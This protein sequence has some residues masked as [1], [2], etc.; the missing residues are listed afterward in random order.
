MSTLPQLRKNIKFFTNGKNTPLVKLSSMVS[1]GEEILAVIAIESP[2]EFN[3]C[4]KIRRDLF[5]LLPADSTEVLHDK[6]YS[7]R[8]IVYDRMDIESALRIEFGVE[9]GS[10]VIDSTTFYEQ[11][12]TLIKFIEVLNN[13]FGYDL[14]TDDITLT[15]TSG[16]N[17]TVTARPNSVVFTGQ[18]S[19]NFGSESDTPPPVKVP[20]H[21]S[22]WENTLIN[23]DVPARVNGNSVSLKNNQAMFNAGIALVQY[24]TPNLAWLIWTGALD[25]EATLTATNEQAVISVANVNQTL[26]KTDE[27]LYAKYTPFI[28][29]TTVPDFLNPITA[30]D[31]VKSMTFSIPYVASLN[32]I[33]TFWINDVIVPITELVKE[34]GSNGFKLVINPTTGASTLTHNGQ[35][36][37]RVSIRVNV[38]TLPALVRSGSRFIY[39]IQREGNNLPLD[40]TGRE[41]YHI[42]FPA[43]E[44]IIPDPSEITPYVPTNQVDYVAA[45]DK[46]N[47]GLILPFADYLKTNPVISTSPTGR[48]RLTASVESETYQPRYPAFYFISQKDW[49]VISGQSVGT[50]LGTYNLSTT[51]A[52]NISITVGLLL[53]TTVP[54]EGGRLLCIVSDI[55]SHIDGSFKLNYQPGSEYYKETTTLLRFDVTYTKASIITPRALDRTI[56]REL[57]GSTMTDPNFNLMYLRQ[58][59]VGRYINQIG[60]A[61][62]VNYEYSPP[63]TPSVVTSSLDEDGLY[64]LQLFSIPSAAMLQ[65]QGIAAR[66]PSA[67]I[68]SINDSAT[69]TTRNLT[70]L[71]IVQTAAIQQGSGDGY[72]YHRLDK[73]SGAT[74]I[75]WVFNCD[76]DEDDL[77]YRQ[78][79]TTVNVANSVIDLPLIPFIVG[80]QECNNEIQYDLFRGVVESGLIEPTEIFDWKQFK[81]VISDDSL[82]GLFVKFGTETPAL[83]TVG[84]L[85]LGVEQSEWIR[86]S[87]FS[88]SVNTNPDIIII[89]NK[90]TEQ[91]FNIKADY[92]KSNADTIG[93]IPL[94]LP[95]F[96]DQV[97]L[98]EWEFE[99]EWFGFG[100]APRPTPSALP[101]LA[102]GKLIIQIQ[103][104]VRPIQNIPSL[105][106]FTSSFTEMEKETLRNKLIEVGK[107]INPIDDIVNEYNVVILEDQVV[108]AADIGL[109]KQDFLTDWV[110]GEVDHLILEVIELDKSILPQ[111]VSRTFTEKELDTVV[112]RFI[113]GSTTNTQVDKVITVRDIRQRAF[114]NVSQGFIPVVGE[115][116][117]VLEFDDPKQ[118]TQNWIADYSILNFEDEKYDPRKLNVQTFVYLNDVS[119][120]VLTLKGIK[121]NVFE[122]DLDVLVSK[123]WTIGELSFIPVADQ[124]I[125]A[126]N[127]FGI[128]NVNYLNKGK[129]GFEVLEFSDNALRLLKTAEKL[130]P[131][132]TVFTL[133]ISSLDVDTK[134]TNLTATELLDKLEEGKLLTIPLTALVKSGDYTYDIAISLN[135]SVTTSITT[136]TLINNLTSIKDVTPPDV[137]VDV[138]WTLPAND[139]EL[140]TWCASVG[141]PPITMTQYGLMVTEFEYTH[142]VTVDRS[143]SEYVVALVVNKAV[144][145][146]LIENQFT[147]NTIVGEF[148]KTNLYIEQ[149][150]EGI[151]NDAGD[152][153]LLV[154]APVSIE[155]ANRYN[156]SFEF[157]GVEPYNQTFTGIDIPVVEATNVLVT[158]IQNSMSQL[159]TSL[160]EALNPIADQLVTVQDLNSVEIT[161]T[162]SI[163]NILNGVSR[164]NIGKKW[165]IP[166]GIDKS[167]LDNLKPGSWLVINI[168]NPDTTVTVNTTQLTQFVAEGWTYRDG[169]T[170]IDY[171][172]YPLLF[173]FTDTEGVVK[174]NS[175][176]DAGASVGRWGPW[177]TNYKTTI[178]FEYSIREVSQTFVEVLIPDQIVVDQLQTELEI[179]EGFIPTNTF[180]KDTVLDGVTVKVNDTSSVSDIGK[181]VPLFV[182]FLTTQLSALPSDITLG[183]VK[184]TVFNKKIDGSYL[185]SDEENII[186]FN[187]LAIENGKVV[188]DH[189]YVL[190]GGVYNSTNP[191]AITYQ[192]NFDFDGDGQDWLSGQS[193]TGVIIELGYNVDCTGALNYAGSIDLTATNGTILMNSEGNQIQVNN[194]SEFTNVLRDTFGL[195]VINI[196]PY[197]SVE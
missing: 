42:L 158:K 70:A 39:G 86:K 163:R 185:P 142:N 49:N 77:T 195:R 54:V 160:R 26:T 2:S 162:D 61:W 81:L 57:A 136:P 164:N 148:N 62:Y 34:T 97:R 152:N 157:D 21:D 116:K 119:P 51:P 63:T 76:Y 11:P 91:V 197:L 64:I 135:S 46:L 112:Y 111:F 165:V 89:R 146:R 6:R 172:V 27:N 145:E 56:L 137:K 65:I 115:I 118:L 103:N 170:G 66:K 93:G 149:I 35:I 72:I 151:L 87:D 138:S 161:E 102:N 78:T 52:T 187:K 168:Q 7:Q 169:A 196:E 183:Q 144:R 143:N 153:I 24:K 188:G 9:E 25:G 147:P 120:A 30:I 90:Y 191:L 38:P 109:N 194:D 83:N 68:L 55:P 79:Q 4:L 101:N 22:V 173:D 96:D 75:Q 182:R 47:S 1:D 19:I 50:I 171:A 176:L 80:V 192:A 133:S 37:A 3:T 139:T 105:F 167:Q 175:N 110:G 189:T 174:Y 126:N 131:T 114:S 184:Q 8:N 23:V 121:G 53:S 159:V 154:R 156:L 124:D 33:V 95:R 134:T 41:L 193:V 74:N 100:N 129:V 130:T 36:D 98:D 13:K 32:K 178:D 20:S 85:L 28:T 58:E 108:D 179:S 31:F 45:M 82:T 14:S 180:G 190:L 132:E 99:F 177:F 69:S 141:L 127:N 104:E 140:A 113:N 122:T 59:E 125:T 106:N 155:D 71:E 60:D 44:I 94:P 12:I 107:T 123:Q 150:T 128:W 15:Y 88:D 166:I 5:P 40:A 43:K 186:S 29:N 92:L 17:Y 48:L 181:R 73:R 16:N 18:A 67:L 117:P 84:R 10:F